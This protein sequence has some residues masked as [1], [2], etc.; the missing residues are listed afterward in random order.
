MPRRSLPRGPGPQG[1][2]PRPAPR[3]EINREL[4][5]AIKQSSKTRAELSRLAGFTHPEAFDSIRREEHVS[6]TPLLIARLVRLAAVLGF[7]A[8]R[9][10]SEELPESERME[11]A[12]ARVAKAEAEIR[13]LLQTSQTESK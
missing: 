5:A 3:R 11:R 6:A 4:L 10:F 13:E 12:R 8:D 1:P 7:P 2:G 9:I